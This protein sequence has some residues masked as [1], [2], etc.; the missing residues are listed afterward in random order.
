MTNSQDDPKG[1]N[2]PECECGCLRAWHPAKV[3]N[4]PRIGKCGVTHQN[5]EWNN[6]TENIPEFLPDC[7]GFVPKK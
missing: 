3:V 7:K 1:P 6:G 2:G 5:P 4:G